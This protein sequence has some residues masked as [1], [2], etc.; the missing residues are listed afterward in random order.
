MAAH[1]IAEHAGSSSGRRRMK[2]QQDGEPARPGLVTGATVLEK[3]AQGGQGFIT[4]G[5]DLGVL[6]SRN[7]VDDDL[8]RQGSAR[9]G[10]AGG[11]SHSSSSRGGT[12]GGSSQSSS[13]SFNSQHSS[14]SGGHGYEQSSH[15]NSAEYDS[16]DHVID[17]DIYDDNGQDSGQQSGGQTSSWSRSNNYA[18]SH[19]RP[20]NAH[21]E[22]VEQQFKHY[23]RTKRE[24]SFSKNEPLCKS[25]RCVNVRCVVGPLEKNAVALIALRTRL[26]IHTVD[27]VRLVN[28]C[29]T[30]SSIKFVFKSLEAAK[31]K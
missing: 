31:R 19:G 17:E 29:Y 4:S 14:S 11:S 8:R 18:F 5:L 21:H 28:Q 10:I 25:T 27:K 3:A 16:D 1:T 22:T 9:G 13:T 6:G 30:K 15:G 2:S 20:L 26:V 23:P 24:V 12:A 7:T